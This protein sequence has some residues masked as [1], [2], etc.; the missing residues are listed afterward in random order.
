MTSL[1][2]YGTNT[3]ATTV[4]TAN[5]LVTGTGAAGTTVG[6]RCGTS[7]TGWGELHAQAFA[8]NWP[9][10]GAIG[11]ASGNGWLLDATTLEGNSILAGN[12]T[13]T[14]NLR[15][16]SS[17]G[18]ATADINVRAFVRS[19][20]GTYTQIG[21]TM[22]LSAQTIN[23][24]TAQ[25]TFSATSLPLQAFNVGDKLYLDAWLHIT[26][27]ANTTSNAQMNVSI[28]SSSTQGVA[29]DMQVVTPGYSVVTTNKKDISTRFVL[30]SP[31]HD[32]KTRFNL[33]V[34]QVKDVATRLRLMS[35]NQL[36]DVSSRL[37][38]RSYYDGPAPMLVVSRNCP[39]Y[40]N[41]NNSNANPGTNANDGDY[42]T[43]WRTQ[44]LTN[45]S[46]DAYIVYDLSGVSSAQRGKVLVNWNNNLTGDYDWTIKSVLAY[47]QPSSYTVDVNAAAGGSLPSSG[48]VTL[49]TVT[50][51]NYNGRQHPINMTGYN[52]VRIN[53]TAINGSPSNLGCALQMDV[54]N[55]ANGVQDDIIF[56]GDSITRGGL[57]IDNGGGA[58][59]VAQQIN[60]QAPANF[61][62]AQGAG[63]GGTVSGDFVTNASTW[64]PLFPGRYVT[65]NYGTNDA[66]NGVATATFKSNM[67]SAI[68]SVIAQGC[69]P[70]IPHIPYGLTGN[71]IANGPAIN[72]AI[73]QLVAANPLVIAGPD[74]WAYFNANQSLIGPDNIH[75]TS[76]GYTALRQLW[77][78][79]LLAT[80]YQTSQSD[81]TSRFRLMSANQLKDTVT[82]FRL[83]SANQLKDTATRLRLMSP[84]QPK[85]VSARFKLD[86]FFQKDVATRFNLAKFVDIQA[87][88]RMMS[89]SQF[90]DVQARLRI[91][92]ANQLRD[93]SSR[94]FLGG[95]IVPRDVSTRFCIIQPAQ[96]GDSYIDWYTRDG[97]M[98]W[99]TRDGNMDW[100]TRGV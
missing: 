88:L 82:R 17:N 36:K 18:A 12:W 38:L 87:R 76:A 50:G 73:D 95:A 54:H 67:Q 70:I 13:P 9:A 27:N 100:Y 3:A 55:C 99:Y 34:K 8:G 32:V 37:R 4:T 26:A 65:L 30:A 24:T 11:S 51:N 49:V 81:V 85:D 98:D 63:I 93:I 42:G 75:P 80:V 91:R 45:I 59:S 41:D 58:G 6:T 60:A 46:N 35:T 89:A 47:N 23:S 92:S 61:P 94:F 28:A 56:F 31:Y 15:Y 40:V 22:V 16:F 5:T 78:S 74:L 69:I 7:V 10:S 21:S 66:N 62:A 79:R 86:S 43:L 39:V 48:W 20:G 1:T 96:P 77:V 84:A 2:T 64:L 68:N 29:N 14:L 33:S 71:I 52:W 90:K 53:C 57:N 25:Y 97:N 72:T 19:S 83:M 44:A